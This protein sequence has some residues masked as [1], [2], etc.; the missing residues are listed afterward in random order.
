MMPF[1]QKLATRGAESSLAVRLFIVA[2]RIETDEKCSRRPDVGIA[3]SYGTRRFMTG[4]CV[5]QSPT[6]GVGDV[7]KGS[8]RLTRE[9]DRADVSG[10]DT[11]G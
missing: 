1:G 3:R 8:L 11:S 5:G 2:I 10:S 9:D 7:E 4:A 6:L